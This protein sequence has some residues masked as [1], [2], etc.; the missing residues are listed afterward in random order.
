VLVGALLC[1]L[2]AL[3]TAAERAAPVLLGPLVWCSTGLGD[4]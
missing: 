1:Q 3:A 4:G 2:A